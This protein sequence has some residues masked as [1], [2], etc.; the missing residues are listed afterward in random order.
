M[1]IIR[2]LQIVSKNNVRKVAKL[3]CAVKWKWLHHLVE[4]WRVGFSFCFHCSQSHR[5]VPFSGD[6]TVDLESTE[7]GRVVELLH[8][9]H[10]VQVFSLRLVLW[11]PQSGVTSAYP[12]QCMPVYQITSNI[13]GASNCAACRT[14]ESNFLI[15][16][17]V[18]NIAGL[19]I[20][21]PTSLSHI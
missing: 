16:R 8:P 19:W 21:N 6:Q 3:F 14:I 10:P 5:L 15:L 1:L 17:P 18:T 4:F 7:Q 20:S 9:R 13:L 11:G 2:V 12:R